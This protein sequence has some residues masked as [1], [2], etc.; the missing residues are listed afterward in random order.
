MKREIC[1]NQKIVFKAIVLNR[2]CDIGSNRYNDLSWQAYRLPCRRPVSTNMNTSSSSQRPR[3]RD[4]PTPPPRVGHV[5]TTAG[6]TTSRWKSAIT[7]HSKTKAE[8]RIPSKMVVERSTVFH[9]QKTDAV[10]QTPPQRQPAD[11]RWVLEELKKLRT[12]VTDQQVE[13]ATS[14]MKLDE[15]IQ[16]IE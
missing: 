2:G 11:R 6:R 9:H 12:D 14:R 3:G 1:A 5:A 4:T 8:N 13:L 16:R 15:I 7:Y 10:S